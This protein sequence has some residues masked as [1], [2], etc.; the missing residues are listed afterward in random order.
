MSYIYIPPYTITSEIEELYK[1]VNLKLIKLKNV[2]INKKDILFKR[3]YSTLNIEGYN[4]DFNLIKDIYNNPKKYDNNL[5][6]PALNTIKAYQKI[7]ALN[8]YKFDDLLKVHSLLMDGLIENAGSLRTQDAGV[9]E[10]TKLIHLAPPSNIIRKHL[11]NLYKW[12]NDSNLLI[13]IKSS[14]FHYE[15]E[16]IHPFL[17]GNGRSGRYLQS[18]LLINKDKIYELLPLEEIIYSHH[19]DYYKAIRTSTKEASSMPFIKFILEIILE[20]LE[21]L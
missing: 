5:L 1:L 8:P 11:D 12:L 2:S 9:F 4:Y 19:F 17:D 6:I 20:Y 18:L 14:I 10:G 21:N 7:N 13:L 15:F 16:F 3:A